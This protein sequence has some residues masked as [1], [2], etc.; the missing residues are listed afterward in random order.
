MY[1]GKRI[2]DAK[3]AFVSNAPLDIEDDT[4]I[5]LKEIRL[6]MY[7]EAALIQYNKAMDLFDKDNG[8]MEIS[9]YMCLYVTVIEEG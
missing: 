9:L 7:K 1:E 4:D 2:K 3:K 5:L 8:D 6:G